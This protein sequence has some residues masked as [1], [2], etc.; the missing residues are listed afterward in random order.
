MRGMGYGKGYR[1]AHDYAGHVVEQ[2]YLPDDLV[3]Q[4][5]FAPSDQGYEARLQERLREIRVA[6][7]AAEPAP[8]DQAQHDSDL[9][10]AFRK[11][12]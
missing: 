10:R 6:S 3:G 12:A 4:H 5:F 2:Q 9:D 7:P 8:T 1:Y 11:D